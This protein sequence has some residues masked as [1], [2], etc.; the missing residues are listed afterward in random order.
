[1]SPAWTW[2][3]NP[4][5]LLEW[6]IQVTID[7]Q[8]PAR[9]PQLVTTAWLKHNY[10]LFLEAKRSWMS[11][12]RYFWL[13]VNHL[14]QRVICIGQGYACT[15]MLQKTTVEFI[16]AWSGSFLQM[17]TILSL[18]NFQHTWH[19]FY[20]LWTH[21]SDSVWQG[22][23]SGTLNSVHGTFCKS[24]I[25]NIV[26]ALIYISKEL[27]FYIGAPLPMAPNGQSPQPCSLHS[28]Y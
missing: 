23:Q 5:D 19:L 21:L 15:R 14:T 26:S 20:G 4:L 3:P 28:H 22:N 2:V 17:L 1:M 16:L 18:G 25:Y 6:M 10:N 8:G 9:V 24:C 27:Y 13:W 12:L 7:L 11:T